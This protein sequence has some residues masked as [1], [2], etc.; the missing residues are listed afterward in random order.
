MTIKLDAATA[1]AAKMTKAEA[2]NLVRFLTLA[3]AE[4]DFD[5]INVRVDLRQNFSD[6][7]LLISIDNNT[8]FGSKGIINE[9]RIINYESVEA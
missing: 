3:I 2:A 1:V 5:T 8:L 4:T 9:T 6:A 7:E